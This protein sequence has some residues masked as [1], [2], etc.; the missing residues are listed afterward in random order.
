MKPQ[1]L[2][3]KAWKR[4]II[5]N[6]EVRSYNIETKDGS[7]VRRKRVHLKRVQPEIPQPEILISTETV[8]QTSPIKVPEAPV[9]TT[10]ASENVYF[11]DALYLF[12]SATAMLV[13]LFV[14]RMGA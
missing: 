12:S 3:N 8:K 7:S 1:T 13:F 6:G 14:N 2:G 9:K 5:L 10:T 11:G 4:G